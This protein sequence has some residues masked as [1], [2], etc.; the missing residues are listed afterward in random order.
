MLVHILSVKEIMRLYF[1]NNSVR[2]YGNK[3]SEII[4]I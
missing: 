1:D 3:K 4:S 2:F